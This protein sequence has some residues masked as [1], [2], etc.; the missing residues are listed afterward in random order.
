NTGSDRVANP[1]AAS[2]FW[3]GA[4]PFA[5]AAVVQGDVLGLKVWSDVANQI[6][7]RDI[8]VCLVPRTFALPAADQFALSEGGTW[9]PSGAI[10]GVTYVGAS[11]FAIGGNFG[12]LDTGLSA[13]PQVGA[14]AGNL[15][16]YPVVLTQGQFVSGPTNNAAISSSRTLYKP[17]GL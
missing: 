11:P 15:Y 14:V 13:T 6:D 10:A 1:S 17:S 4:S 8:T 7:I 2:P 5:A 16:A 12:W 3:Y 9:T